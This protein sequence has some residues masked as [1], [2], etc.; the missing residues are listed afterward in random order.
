MKTRIV[1][2]GICLVLSGA[3]QAQAKYQACRGECIKTWN[4]CIA[5]CGG[6][7]VSMPW[8]PVPTERL[9]KV[10]DCVRSQCRPSLNSCNAGCREPKPG[11]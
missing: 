9:T 1:L 2:A 3:S 6:T 7:N 5:G 11:Q 8:E 4:A 10:N